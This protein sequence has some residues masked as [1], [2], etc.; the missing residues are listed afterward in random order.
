MY[1]ER[2]RQLEGTLSYPTEHAKSSVPGDTTTE[3]E[4]D[5]SAVEDTGVSSA[6]T[7]EFAG[8]GIGFAS[9]LADTLLSHPFIVIRGQCQVGLFCLLLNVLQVMTTGS[10]IHISPFSLVPIV[11]KCVKSQGPAFLWKGLS[12]VFVVRG[13]CLLSDNVISELTSLPREV[14]KLSSLRRLGAHVLLR[15][16]SWVL[17]APFYAASIVEIVQVSHNFSLIF[18]S[19]IF[20]IAILLF[21]AVT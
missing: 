18:C 4:H 8:L 20:P 7:Y 2:L 3:E 13:L 12:S 10:Y 9:M 17:V 1:A 5:N 16:L 6:L 19:C 11:S 15:T 14:S 21:M